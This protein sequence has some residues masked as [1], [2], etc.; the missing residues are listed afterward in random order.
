M[1]QFFTI[2]IQT[3]GTSVAVDAGSRWHRRHAHI[4]KLQRVQN[5]L[6]RVTVQQGKFDRMAP[7]LKELHW[8]P[9]EKRITF[10][11]ATRSYNFKSTGQPVY[12]RELLSDCQPVC[13]L[14][15]SSK[16]LL[17]V[18]IAE[19]VLA[20]RGFRHSTVAVWNSLQTVFATLPTLIF[21]NV[22]LRH[23]YLTLHSS[24][25]SGQSVSTNSI[26]AIHGT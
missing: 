26:Y 12:L 13:T 20:T 8:L 17:T 23:A 3:K 5:T 10:K 16:L 9:F 2:T 14:R 19:T 6:A 25:S 11:L 24:P 4:I 18:N 22:R 21:L 7:V 15:S 1:T